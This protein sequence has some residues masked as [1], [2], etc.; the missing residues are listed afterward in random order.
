MLTPEQYRGVVAERVQRG[1][2]RLN[3]VQI[4]P[5]TAVVG[6]WSVYFRSLH[7]AVQGQQARNLHSLRSSVTEDVLRAADVLTRGL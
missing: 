2:G 1:G 7:R 4:G 5:A 6:L 3:S